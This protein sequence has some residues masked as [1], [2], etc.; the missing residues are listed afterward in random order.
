MLLCNFSTLADAAF[1]PYN[2]SLPGGTPQRVIVSDPLADEIFY[3]HYIY[4]NSLDLSFLPIGSYTLRHA[5]SG[6][7]W[8]RLAIER[9][10]FGINVSAYAEGLHL[11]GKLPRRVK[12]FDRDENTFIDDFW[13]YNSTFDMPLPAGRYIVYHAASGETW[14][15][16][17]LA[18]GLNLPSKQLAVTA[19]TERPGV[20]DIRWGSLAGHSAYLIKFEGG[21]SNQ[22]NGWYYDDHLQVKLPPGNYKVSVAPPSKPYSTIEFRVLC[23]PYVAHLG[24]EL[25]E[26]SC[27]DIAP[28]TFST[29]RSTDSVNS[30]R[31]DLVD[32]GE[33]ELVS[34]TEFCAVLGCSQLVSGTQHRISLG[35]SEIIWIENQSTAQTPA[36]ISAEILPVIPE[37]RNG[38]L[39][40]PIRFLAERLHLNS[41]YDKQ[42]RTVT[43]FRIKTDAQQL[44]LKTNSILSGSTLDFSYFKDAYETADSL[45]V[46]WDYSSAIYRFSKSDYSFEELTVPPSDGLPQE[47]SALDP[48]RIFLATSGG[49]ILELLADTFVPVTGNGGVTLAAP[50]DETSLTHFRGSH[51]TRLVADRNTEQLY[52]YDETQ[53]ALFVA[54]LRT[55]RVRM[56]ANSAQISS[57]IDLE[58]YHGQPIVMQNGNVL[59]RITSSGSVEQ[60]GCLASLFPTSQHRIYSVKYNE[61]AQTWLVLSSAQ[62][63][64]YEAQLPFDDETGPCQIL[65]S[66]YA[67]DQ[68]AF[69]NGFGEIDPEV[70]APDTELPLDSD[71]FHL[72]RYRLGGTFTRISSVDLGVQANTRFLGPVA[73]AEHD[74]GI[75]VLGNQTHQVIRFDESTGVYTPFLGNGSPQR[76]SLSGVDNLTI[77]IGYPN[78]L[79]FVGDS[80]WIAD[81]FNRRIVTTQG[82]I[83]TQL[84]PSTDFTVQGGV[85]GF[86][87]L[88]GHTYILDKQ[89]GG[90]FEHVAGITAP[91]WIA[92]AIDP[93][94]SSNSELVR[95]RAAR[96]STLGMNSFS[97]VEFGLPVALDSFGSNQLTVVD[98]YRHGVWQLNLNDRSVSQLMGFRTRAD[99]H[100]GAFTGNAGIEAKEFRTGSPTAIEYDHTRHIFILSLGFSGEVAFIRE[101]LSKVCIGRPDLPAQY[102]AHAIFLSD[103]RL[104]ITDMSK[105]SVTLF[106]PVG[107]DRCL[108][109]ASDS[110]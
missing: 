75:Y 12:V 106:D 74:S 62:R 102:V 33:Y 100:F 95:R 69:L 57:V 26:E 53:R 104:A 14:R 5:V 27:L 24:T 17:E 7:P 32:A 16:I 2:I 82:G 38:A 11:P 79:K 10:T 86:T 65:S 8:E 101:D 21:S 41:R 59:N 23:S 78:Y 15:R 66:I 85:G 108:S 81:H 99:Y 47:F 34:L 93:Q 39:L 22:Y 46:G 30:F 49:L 72:I 56:I 89:S 103:G 4:G 36:S 76:N 91:R 52:F 6:L 37:F 9:T 110:L 18:T 83:A 94:W 73:V 84:F 48:T 42:N 29:V 3:D 31:P 68:T 70:G 98:Q 28:H 88:A 51:I 107:L 97:N 80:L 54:D 58:S 25:G 40:F 96:G 45:Y 50:G 55:Q 90:M 13:W 77:G 43:V 35:A 19:L 109:S 1:Q 61:A 64:I 92:G 67:G 105:N 71:G 44:S 20:V 60:N 63:Q 87:E